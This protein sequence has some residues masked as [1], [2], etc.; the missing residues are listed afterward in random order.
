MV[1]THTEDFLYDSTTHVPLIINYP[2]LRKSGSVQARFKWA[3]V[4]EFEE[5]DGKKIALPSH[6]ED[7]FRY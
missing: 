2:D 7:L 1:K 6:Y 5:L 4:A 3:R